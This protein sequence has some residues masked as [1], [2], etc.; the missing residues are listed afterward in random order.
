MTWGGQQAADAPPSL[1]VL[2]F[3]ALK[4]RAICA[5]LKRVFTV[6]IGP[7]RYYLAFVN[8]VK[9]PVC[10][11]HTPVL[12]HLVWPA[13][14]GLFDVWLVSSVLVHRFGN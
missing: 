12:G 10:S 14:E 7:M 9:L 2:G 1:G 13:P 5:N 8:P 4:N 6:E 11:P 3:R